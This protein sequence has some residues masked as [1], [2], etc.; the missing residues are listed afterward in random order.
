MTWRRSVQRAASR[1]SNTLQISF[2]FGISMIAGLTRG[3]SA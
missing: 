2:K 1:R 3:E